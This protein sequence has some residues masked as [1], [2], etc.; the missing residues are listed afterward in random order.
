[1]S[2]AGHPFARSPLHLGRE[3]GAAIYHHCGNNV[4][5]WSPI[6]TK[7]YRQYTAEERF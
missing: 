2:L 5:T 3:R 7:S 6:C 1:M 4:H